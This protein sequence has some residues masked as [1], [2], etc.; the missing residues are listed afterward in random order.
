MLTTTTT[1]L[2]R[3][4]IAAAVPGGAAADQFAG[5]P[6]GTS[7]VVE[8]L[9]ARQSDWRGGVMDRAGCEFRVET[10]AE[11]TWILLVAAPERADALLDV[12]LSW[13]GDVRFDAEQLAS[14]LRVVADEVRGVRRQIRRTLWN[15]LMADLA[16]DSFL[17]ADVGGEPDVLLTLPASAVATYMHDVAPFTPAVTHIRD[18]RVTVAPPALVWRPASGVP[19]R[20]EHPVSPRTG[21]DRTY[22]VMGARRYPGVA[23]DPVPALLQYAALRYSKLHPAQ[24]SLIELGVK[25]FR[26]DLVSYGTSNYLT[27]LARVRG[28]DTARTIDAVWAAL[29]QPFAAGEEDRARRAAIHHLAATLDNP[30]HSAVEGACRALVGA[31]PLEATYERLVNL[32]AYGMAAAPPR[33]AVRIGAL[34]DRAPR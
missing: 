22:V 34:P 13:L 19:R 8:H 29:E 7:H 31:E 21:R 4:Y 10:N 26:F 6:A 28:A 3:S 12:V 16:P 33:T 14:E 15:R 24:R 20:L 27:A 9:L 23:E 30:R 11:L 18:G 1:S 25:L 32:D 2:R 5:V 17:S